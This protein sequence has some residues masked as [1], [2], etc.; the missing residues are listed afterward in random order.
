MIPIDPRF[1]SAVSWADQTIL[2]L[3]DEAPIPRLLNE[4]DWKTW[5]A[6]LIL[7][8]DIAK[9]GPAQPQMFNKWRDWAA[10]FNETIRLVDN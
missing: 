7:T 9:L 5:A 4:D 1:M 2:V 6:Y 10:A 8:P 3:S